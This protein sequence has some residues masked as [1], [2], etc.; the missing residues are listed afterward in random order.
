MLLARVEAQRE[1]SDRLRALRRQPRATQDAVDDAYGHRCLRA[2]QATP[3]C[4]IR[5]ASAAKPRASS[6]AAADPRCVRGTPRRP[7]CN[8]A[9]VGSW[10]DQTTSG[11]SAHDL[12][13]TGQVLTVRSTRTITASG[14]TVHAFFPT[15]AQLPAFRRDLDGSVTAM[16]EL[17]TGGPSFPQAGRVSHIIGRMDMANRAPTPIA[18]GVALIGDA[19]LAFHPLW[20]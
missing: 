13:Q 2:A 4:L 9:R 14:P 15:R 10:S 7:A 17:L 8:I 6:R 12:R 11:R 20:A 18:P 3:G 19:A 16:L 5:F 1:Q